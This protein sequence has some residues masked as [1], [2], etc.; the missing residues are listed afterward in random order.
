MTLRLVECATPLTLRSVALGRGR[1][2]AT[3]S[4]AVAIGSEAG[5]K[6]R[7]DWPVCAAAATRFADGFR[8][9]PDCDVS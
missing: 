6:E 2:A 1:N 8:L 5:G 4:L 9:P 3:A 7:R